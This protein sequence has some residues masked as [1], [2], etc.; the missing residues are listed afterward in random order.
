MLTKTATASVMLLVFTLAGCSTDEQTTDALSSQ[1]HASLAVEVS[2]VVYATNEQWQILG[3]LLPAQQILLSMEV[4]GKV[5]ERR[6][7]RGDHVAK[8]RLLIRLDEQ[9][10]LLKRNALDASVSQLEADLQLAKNDRDRLQSLLKR[11]LVS[12]QDVDQIETRIQSLEAQLTRLAQ[13]RALANRQIDYTQLTAPVT[14]RINRVMI[15]PGQQVQP[16][17][18]LLELIQTDELI[19][20]TQLPASRMANLPQQ[21][22][23]VTP[24]QSFGLIL[25]EQEPLADQNTGLFQVRYQLA[26]DQAHLVTELAGLPLGERYPVQFQQ[27][28]AVALQ[29]IPASALIDLGQGPHVWIIDNDRAQ[30]TP[31][32]LVRLHNGAALIEPSLAEDALIVRHGVHRLQPDQA[33]R[34]LNN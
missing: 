21:A 13:E 27:P 5:T 22:T 24:S 3:Q 33:V 7:K 2:D 6:V 25:Y 23:L 8:G 14:G 20:L 28:L 9:D 1:Q 10:L 26:P 11:Q 17:Q 34:I 12:Q 15:E 29:K 30:L 4:G 32:K 19:V 18:I 16:G 31:I